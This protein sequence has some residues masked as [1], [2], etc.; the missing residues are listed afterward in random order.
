MGHI[1]NKM[2]IGRQERKRKT[3][4]I[5]RVTTDIKGKAHAER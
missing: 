1:S 5:N 4:Q 2:N 3:N